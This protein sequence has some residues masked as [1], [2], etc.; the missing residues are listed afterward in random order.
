MKTQNT[1]CVPCFK[2]WSRKGCGVFASLGREVKIGVLALSMSLIVVDSMATQADTTRTERLEAISVV[3]LRGSAAVRS[4]SEPARVVAPEQLTFGANSSIESMLR[5]NARLDIRQRGARGT[6]ADI[7]I[8]GASPDQAMVLLNGV[9]FSDARTGHQ[10]HSLP[11]P[12]ASI[13]A[14]DFISNTQSI[15]AYAG[16]LDYRS[17][18]P[19]KNMLTAEISGGAFG[20]FN[21]SIVGGVRGARNSLLLAASYDHSDG[22]TQNTDFSKLNVYLRA[23]HSDKHAGQFDFQ[24]GFQSMDFGANSFY[25][26]TYRQQWEATRTAL[27]SVVWNKT[28][29]KLNLG[30]LASY[31]FNT[32]RFELFRPGTADIPSWYKGAN[33]HLTDNA[34]G[35]LWASYNWGRAGVTSLGVDYTYNHIW[36]TVL[37]LA[38]DEKQLLGITYNHAK[39]RDAFSYYLRHSVD[40]GA[41]DLGVS[42]SLNSSK[43]Y[44]LTPL[45]SVMVGY[46]IVR[47]LRLEAS[48]IA[49]MRLPT[50]TDLYYTTATHVGSS[51]LVPERA[52]TFNLS[53]AY[54]RGGWSVSGA[55]YYRMGGDIIDWVR[56]VGQDIWHSEQITAINT[57]GLELQAGYRAERGCLQ[58]VSLSYA[59][60]NSDKKTPGDKISKYALDYMRHKASMVVN[61]R[62]VRNLIFNVTASYAERNGGYEVKVGELRP[63]A[64]YFLLDSRL[65]WTLAR[66]VDLWVE[67]SNILGSEYFDFGG[68]V[69]PGRWAMGGVRVKL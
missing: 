52:T 60:I 56:P 18:V 27:A 68:I 47:G 35:S 66:R 48:G 5:L 37:G 65:T 49:S 34:A 51:D 8:R 29:G 45:W 55:A 33:Y 14:V 63:Y 6:Q 38:T 22:Y 7:S 28:I 57:F 31:R 32:D 13:A 25:S 23:T 61:F 62:I 26:L 11:L 50:F 4:L 16:A 10:S 30:A 15:G 2:H 9:N 20:T 64:P 43:D 21:S 46:D 36:S 3:A 59:Y 24:A 58:E 1:K 69:L 19:Q 17:I 67:C 41:V 44:G 54:A 40:L 53:L 39:D 42:A 12:T